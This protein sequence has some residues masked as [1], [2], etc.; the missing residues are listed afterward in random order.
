MQT[1]KKGALK[2]LT[3]D[4]YP[5]DTNNYNKIDSCVDECRFSTGVGGNA[6]TMNAS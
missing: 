2:H 1:N 4:R 3:Y 6:W 5:L